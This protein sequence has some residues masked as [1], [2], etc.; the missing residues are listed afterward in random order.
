M[1]ETHGRGHV[2]EKVLLHHKARESR[3]GKKKNM[4][5]ASQNTIQSA[6]PMTEDFP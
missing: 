2:V 5:L 4:G 6:V 3:D 1:P